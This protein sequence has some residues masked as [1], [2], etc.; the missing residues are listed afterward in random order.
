MVNNLVIYIENENFKNFTIK[1]IKDEFYFMKNCYCKDR[2]NQKPK[3]TLISELYSPTLAQINE[4]CKREKQTTRGEL[5]LR[6]KNK[7]KGLILFH[8]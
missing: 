5:S 2:N 7:G 8:G 3:P 6:M 1:M 4:F